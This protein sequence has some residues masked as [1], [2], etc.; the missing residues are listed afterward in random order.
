VRD[1]VGSSDVTEIVLEDSYHMATLD[2]DAER[3][4]K[5]SLAFVARVAGA[6]APGS[7]AAGEGAAS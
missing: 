6:A 7:P 2:N 5:E 3:I 4:E 1:G